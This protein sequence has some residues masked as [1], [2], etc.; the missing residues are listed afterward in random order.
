MKEACCVASTLLYT[1]LLLVKH[2][3]YATINKNE[4]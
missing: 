1:K 2:E 4:Y 3:F